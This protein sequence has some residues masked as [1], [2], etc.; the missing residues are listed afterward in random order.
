MQDE[1]ASK[2]V[3]VTGAETSNVNNQP[4]WAR[5]PEV[6]KLFGIK[7]TM[8][9]RFLAEGSIRSVSLR[10]RGCT[11]GVRIIDCDSVR[12]FLEQHAKKEM[13]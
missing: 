4:E 7:R 5:I 10:R 13:K 9:F 1:K 11:K 2:S 3:P 8:L 6:T 12:E